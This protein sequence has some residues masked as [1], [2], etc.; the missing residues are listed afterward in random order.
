MS[1]LRKLPKL[2]ADNTIRRNLLL[3]QGYLSGRIMALEEKGKEAPAEKGECDAA[4]S[5]LAY[6]YNNVLPEMF[7]SAAH[8]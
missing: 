1:S 5:E 8:S 2:L 7:K 6:I 3:F 4:I